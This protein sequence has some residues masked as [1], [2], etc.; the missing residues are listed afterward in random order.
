MAASDFQLFPPLGAV[1]ILFCAKARHLS[2]C[3]GTALQPRRLRRSFASQSVKL[4]C[5]IVKG[6]LVNRLGAVA[7]IFCEKARHASFFSG[8]AQKF[9]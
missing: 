7:I 9:C 3:A 1:A 8:T 4:V 6:H 5:E 2:F